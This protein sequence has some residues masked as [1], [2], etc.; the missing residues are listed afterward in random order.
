MWMPINDVS[1]WLYQFIVCIAFAGYST[2]NIGREI[3]Q[4]TSDFKA[5]V[6]SPY[7]AFEFL[8]GLTFIVVVVMMITVT[9]KQANID[10]QP[11]SDNV[12]VDAAADSNLLNIASHSVNMQKLFAFTFVLQTFH[13]IRILRLFPELGPQMQAIGQTLTDVKVWQFFVFL[14]FCIIGCALTVQTVFGAEQKGFATLQDSMLAVYRFVWGDWDF[15]EIQSRE[16]VW[17]DGS[18][19]GYAV[20]LILTFVITGTLANVFIAIVAE[21]YNAHLDD[22]V[23]KW[24]EEV[25]GIMANW[26]GHAFRKKFPN[27][28]SS[29][30]QLVV[31]SV[32]G[33]IARDEDTDDED[34]SPIKDSQRGKGNQGRQTLA[35]SID[36]VNACQ[37]AQQRQ[38]EDLRDMM[39]GLLQQHGQTVK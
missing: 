32:K 28:E 11:A 37:K 6:K 26:Y 1:S 36:K 3:W 17:T 14:G 24:I 8:R 2:F 9:V 22:S 30:Y 27:K 21:R 18:A 13:L 12:Y 35:A 10:L 20:F 34:D 15:A 33:R 19:W 4:V 31:A 39:K 7:E 25:D 23:N 29:A 38:L 16:Y 5:Y